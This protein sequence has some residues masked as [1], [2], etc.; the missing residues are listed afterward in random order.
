MRMSF[1]LL[2]GIGCL[3]T[4]E[5]VVFLR[6]VGMGRGRDARSR[7]DF[8]RRSPWGVSTP[9]GVRDTRVKVSG[10]TRVLSWVVGALYATLGQVLGLYLPIA[11]CR[12]RRVV[13]RGAPSLVR[14]HSRTTL[15]RPCNK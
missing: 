9:V 15:L 5:N 3:Q 14:D 13:L 4:M 1:L 6:M 8:L 7:R 2:R 10:V 12:M 11:I